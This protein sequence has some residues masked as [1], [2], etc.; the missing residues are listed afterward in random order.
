MRNAVNIDVSDINDPT[1][2]QRTPC[3]RDPT[4]LNKTVQENVQMGNS[5]LMEFENGDVL[6]GTTVLAQ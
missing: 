1:P 5:A 4:L 2:T 6:D 3:G